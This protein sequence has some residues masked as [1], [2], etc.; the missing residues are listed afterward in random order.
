MVSQKTK[1]R[2]IISSSNLTPRYI[3]K[4]RKLVYQRETPVLPCL[5]YYNIFHIT[6]VWK[7]PKCPSTDEW[8]KNMWCT[9]TMEYYST[10]E[11]NEN[12]S[13]AITWV[14]MKV[15]MLSKIS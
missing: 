6:K 11:K 2:S 7:Q 15:V 10:K 3:L 9:H 13:C 1:N 8:I 5:V 12:L 4:K 14:E